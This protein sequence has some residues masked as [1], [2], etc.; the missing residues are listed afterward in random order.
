MMANV[1]G[2]IAAL[3]ALDAAALPSPW[4]M[5]L[6]L[7]LGW[8]VVLAWVGVMLTSAWPRQV[9]LA[10]ASL[11]MAW[12]WVPGPYAPVHWLGLAFQAPSL[13]TVLLC[14]LVL[15]TRLFPAE[16]DGAERSRLANPR[17]LTLAG[18]GVVL[19]WLLLLDALAMLPVELYAWGF[20]PAATALAFGTALLPWMLSR[21]IR[22]VGARQW[23]AA[24]SVVLFVGL[25]LPTGN[26]WDALLDPWLWVALHVYVVKSVWFRRTESAKSAA[27]LQAEGLSFGYPQ[28]ALF[29]GWS[30]RFAPGVTLVR[31]GDGSG[32]TTLLRMLAGEL[33][34]HAGHLRVNGT[35]LKEDA[36]AYRQQVFWVD[37]RSQA[38]DQMTALDYFS[39]L[40]SQY[41]GFDLQAATALADGLLLRPHLEKPLYML[42][43]GSKRKVWLAAAFASGAAVTLLDEPFAALDKASI[44]FVMELLREAAGHAS[45]AWV[46]ADYELP[47]DL[48]LAGVVEL[49]G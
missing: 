11:L 26:V 32:K 23:V 30:A 40:R 27:V 20:S 36:R 43:S 17:G 18:L 16:P 37:P 13:S 45:R 15:Y 8:S 24:T 38:F 47:G 4:L 21:G 35:A 10:L 48:A 29:T 42:S 34:A 49:G 41:P 14:A 1:G 6:E 19:G 28:R 7:F 9:R 39:A 44:A 25:R 2:W 3:T 33:P 31:G 12:C 46:V 5:R 22:S